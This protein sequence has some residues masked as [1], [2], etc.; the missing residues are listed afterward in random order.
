MIR[1][2]GKINLADI[3][4]QKRKLNTEFFDTLNSIIDWKKIEKQ[5]NDIYKK[6]SR[7]G[8]RPAYSGLLLFKMCLLEKW[9]NISASELED[10]INDS[11]TLTHFIGL[12]LA[13]EIPSY[14]T[15]L[16]FK[17]IMERKSAGMDVYENIK[18]ILEKNG[19]EIIVGKIRNPKLKKIIAGKSPE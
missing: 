9:Y 7:L 8:G 15:L 17:K 10:K 2:D 16:R 5:I 14:S 18:N 13:D 12:S 19:Y 1:K 3:E 11:I 4:V 6:G